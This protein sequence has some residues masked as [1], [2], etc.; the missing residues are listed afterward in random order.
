M[1][2]QKTVKAIAKRF[3]KTSTGKILKVK[4]GQNHFNAGESGK[5]KRNKRQDKN[6]LN[7]K[8]SKLIKRLG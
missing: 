6:I 1:S 2:K 7:K 8:D 3:K 5:T 4:S